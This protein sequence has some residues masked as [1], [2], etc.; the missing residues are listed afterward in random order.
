MLTASVSV[1]WS[2]GLFSSRSDV[3]ELTAQKL[4]W[5]VTYCC[6]FWMITKNISFLKSTSSVHSAS[7]AFATMRYINWSFT[8]L[9]T[10]LFT[11][12]TWEAEIIYDCLHPS[13][14]R[15]SRWSLPF[16]Q[17]DS[18]N[19]LV[20][21]GPFSR[22]TLGMSQHQNSL[23]FWISWGTSQPPSPCWSCPQTVRYASIVI[24]EWHTS[25]SRMRVINHNWSATKHRLHLQSVAEISCQSVLWSHWR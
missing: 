22:T 14:P 9:L 25:S 1:S 8:Y 21:F 12:R 18:N 19:T 6:C 7:E 13:N 10:Y 17:W 23:L 5:P 3:M 11:C 24:H 4:V 16:F 2:S 20:F 15:T